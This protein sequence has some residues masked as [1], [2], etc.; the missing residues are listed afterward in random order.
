MI[1]Y[2]SIECCFEE[3]CLSVDAIYSNVINRRNR[4]IIF[5]ASPRFIQQLLPLRLLG[6]SDDCIS[7]A[8]LHSLLRKLRDLVSATEC[9]RVLLLL[10]LRLKGIIT[11]FITEEVVAGA[12]EILLSSGSAVTIIIAGNVK[13]VQGLIMN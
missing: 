8:G 13:L 9:S 10:P 7:A 6:L 5:T 12:F 11:D 2:P 1:G 4:K 3:K